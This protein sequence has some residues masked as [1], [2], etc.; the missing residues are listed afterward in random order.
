MHL[1]HYCI[2]CVGFFF[3]AK[4][5]WMNSLCLLNLV[6]PDMYNRSLFCFKKRFQVHTSKKFISFGL[7]GDTHF[8]EKG[9]DR[10][11]KTGS[12]ISEEFKKRNVDVIVCLGDVLNTRDFVNVEAQS[13]AFDMFNKMT[14]ENPSCPVHIVLGNHDMNLRHSRRI[15]SLDGLRMGARSDI[16]LHTQIT[17]LEIKG[18]QCLFIPYHHEPDDIIKYV[19]ELSE[20]MSP[21]KMKEIVVFGH[22]SVHGAKQNDG[23]R[24][25][26]AIHSSLFSPFKHTFSGH[27]HYYHTLENN[28]VY[29][30]SPMQFNFG[31][32]GDERGCVVYD[33]QTDKMIHVAN[34]FSPRFY[35]MPEQEVEQ[36]LKD[37]VSIFKDAHVMIEFEHPKP[38]SVFQDLREKLVALGCLDVRRFHAVEKVIKNRQTQ[39]TPAYH[40]IPML[41]EE[42]VKSIDKMLKSEA[43]DKEQKSVQQIFE[44]EEKLKLLIGILR[45]FSYYMLLF[46]F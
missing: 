2:L 20:R 22:L 11:Q 46:S 9:L 26:G 23:R 17:L 44:N 5:K 40:D 15:S 41:L 29:V 30:G 38:F 13:A 21:E 42:Y 32:A 28:V 34:T 35:K 27:Y 10:I 1:L 16:H 25:H 19:N 3:G 14:Y 36:N 18:V 43:N 39:Y 37:N 6:W 33:S 24:F 7:F 31:D 8:Q 4:T 12:W 45:S